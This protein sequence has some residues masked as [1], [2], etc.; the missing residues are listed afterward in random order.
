VVSA[1]AEAAAESE[2]SRGLSLVAALADQWG[3]EGN[4]SGRAVWFTLRWHNQ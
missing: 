1:A 4:R 2:N 3:H